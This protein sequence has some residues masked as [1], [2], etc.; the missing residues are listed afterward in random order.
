MVTHDPVNFTPPKI[1]VIVTLHNRRA[2]TE[3][4]FFIRRLRNGLT[5][6]STIYAQL[7]ALPALKTLLTPLQLQSKIRLQIGLPRRHTYLAIINPLSLN[8]FCHAPPPTIRLKIYIPR[9]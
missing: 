2:P 8:S 1:D 7:L 9:L 3:N 4:T 6:V 5:V